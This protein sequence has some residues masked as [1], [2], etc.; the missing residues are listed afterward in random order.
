M[1]IMIVD[2]SSTIRALITST[3]KQLGSVQTETACDGEDAL[4]KVFSFEP[5]LILIDWNMPKMSGL[6]FLKQFRARNK[7]T[8]VIMVTTEAEKSRVI[9]AIRAGINDYV[10]KPF[11]PDSLISHV[12][13]TMQKAK[14]A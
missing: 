5:D 6:E 10:V 2:D 3:L 1:K 9:E 4:S 7:T 14:A 8:P 13:T 11:T 12:R